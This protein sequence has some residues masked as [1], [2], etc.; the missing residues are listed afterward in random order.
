MTA[1]RTTKAARALRAI[2]SEARAD[3]SRAN[4]SK[5]GRK[6][7][8]G[9]TTRDLREA[10][11]MSARLRKAHADRVTPRLRAAVAAI[12]ALLKIPVYRRDQAAASRAIG[13]HHRAFGE[14]LR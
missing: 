11:R 6:R 9:P 7:T 2:P 14:A 13:E 10:L 12:D 4:G 5:G 3:A 1:D 8:P